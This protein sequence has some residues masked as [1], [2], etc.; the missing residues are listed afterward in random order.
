MALLN[1][2]AGNPLSGKA[3]DYAAESFKIT[4]AGR[5]RSL[6]DMLGE[7]NAQITEGVPADLLKRKQDNLNRQ[8]EIAEQ[9]TGISL[10]GDQ[11]QKPADLEKE[12][13]KLQTEFDEIENQIRAGSPRYA[14]LTGGQPLTLAETQQKVLDEGTVLLEYSLGANTSYLFAVAASGVS[15]FKLPA[16][17]SIDKLATDFRAP[18]IPPKLQRRIVGIDVAEP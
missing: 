5:A 4:E 11:K 2:P 12:L 8:Q 18:L 6:L 13:D 17:S 16:R 9:L 14:E 15:L 1:S 3:L 10:S 7:V